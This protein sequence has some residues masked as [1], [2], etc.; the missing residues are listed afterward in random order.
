M[1]PREAEMEHTGAR[2][3]DESITGSGGYDA[4]LHC[5]GQ[6]KQLHNRLS[7]DECCTLQP[8]HKGR[9]LWPCTAHEA[10][11][12]LETRRMSE[13]SPVNQFKT[14]WYFLIRLSIISHMEVNPGGKL[15]KVSDCNAVVI[16]CK[17]FLIQEP[18]NKW[19]ES[20]NISDALLA[21]PHHHLL[22][23]SYEAI[24]VPVWRT[25]GAWPWL[26]CHLTED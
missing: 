25:G 15:F 26:C 24:F 14:L 16:M 7:E 13:L 4:V 21:V 12:G 19:S 22:Q 23:D 9:F 10:E 18:M 20:K 8:T 2:L 3:P 6:P 17:C 5:D 1:S 11:D